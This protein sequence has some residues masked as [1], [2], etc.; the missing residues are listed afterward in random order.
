MLLSGYTPA[1][2]SS[3]SGSI[4]TTSTA[5]TTTNGSGSGNSSTSNI[6][7]T[8]TATT[9]TTNT[10]SSRSS[11][12]NTSASATSTTITTT[13]VTSYYS[14]PLA[15]AFCRG[16]WASFWDVLYYLAAVSGNGNG[17]SSL[18]V[19]LSQFS[20]LL[21]GLPPQVK[22]STRQTET[23]RKL[24]RQCCQEAVV[25][26]LLHKVS[27]AENIYLNN[28]GATAE[29]ELRLT[30]TTTTMTATIAATAATATTIAAATGTRTG[31]R[32][33]A[34]TSPDSVPAIVK[35][36]GFIENG[37]IR[38][39]DQHTYPLQLVNLWLL[40]PPAPDTT[41]NWLQIAARLQALYHTPTAPSEQYHNNDD[42]DDDDH[43]D[44]QQQHRDRNKQRGDPDTIPPATTL[45]RATLATGASLARRLE[46]A[47][48]EIAG[49][50][51]VP[52]RLAE[53]FTSAPS[54]PN[55]LYL[56]S[57]VLSEPEPVA[58]SASERTAASASE[59]AAA[60]EIAQEP[61][62]VAVKT[63]AAASIMTSW[64]KTLV[65]YR[66]LNPVRAGLLEKLVETAQIEPDEYKKIWASLAEWGGTE[67]FGLLREALN[68]RMTTTT[69]GRFLS[70]REVVNLASLLRQRRELTKEA[71]STASNLF[72][73]L[74]G[75]RFAGAT[76]LCRETFRPAFDLEGNARGLA[77]WRLEIWA[78][79]AGWRNFTDNPARRPAPETLRLTL[80]DGEFRPVYTT[81]PLTIEPTNAKTSWRF[82][83]E[84]AFTE[85]RARTPEPEL[86]FMHI[87][88]VRDG[89]ATTPA[90]WFS[91]ATRLTYFPRRIGLSGRRLP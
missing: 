17:T 20:R 49:L 71:T 34:A 7:T 21:Y 81:P 60:A 9:T 38:T 56:G 25:T 65:N 8:I 15:L 14:L 33:V 44:H 36:V 12:S 39:F 79:V 85:W 83:L 78:Q 68:W 53:Q 74:N 64:E 27:E 63:A 90:G 50:G 30:L 62:A 72:N 32:T 73:R 87:E 91:F 82:E 84:G 6:T 58:A 41:P 1:S 54:S 69:Q 80:Y 4:S 89:N 61:S 67:D 42:H 40:E 47:G 35:P 52:H 57:G 19:R 88:A 13:N 48:R 5:A 86:R 75:W 26:G 18:R 76:T 37:W 24:F 70:W 66:R 22:L 55:A 51:L 59:R 16:R 31:T 10:D 77:R 11:S 28:F 45:Y 2:S 23:A 43:R 29:H 46:T 3:G